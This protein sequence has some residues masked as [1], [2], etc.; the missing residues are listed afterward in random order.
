MAWESAGGMGIAASGV[1]IG[2]SVAAGQL[3]GDAMEFDHGLIGWS[4]RCQRKT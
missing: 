1:E 2:P 3:S 4:H